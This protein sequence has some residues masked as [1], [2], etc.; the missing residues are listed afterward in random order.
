MDKRGFG[1]IPVLRD[2][3]LAGLA[4]RADGCYFDGTFGRGGHARAILERLG[5]AGRLL[6]M[7]RD[8][9]AI[10][11]AQSEFG[12]D[13]RVGIR[14]GNFS[15]VGAWDA[16]CAGLDGALLDLG[17]SSPQLDDAAR[18]FSFQ[19]DAPLDMR[20]DPTAG[21]SAADFLAHADASAI[22]DVLFRFGEERM[23]RRIAGAIVAQRAQA[24]ITTTRALAALVERVL[25]RRGRGKHPAT[26][27]FQALRI[28]VN[29]ELGS[30]QR[31][32]PALAAALR[33]G[34]RLAVI[35]FH[36]L[37]DRIVKQ[38]MRGPQPAAVRRGLPQPPVAPAPLRAIGR[39]QKAEAGEVAANP[40]ARSAVLRLAEKVAAEG[41]A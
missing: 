34:G 29:D 12:H 25:G 8:P 6:V 23:S 1:H 19:A 16:A 40:R 36:S 33:P 18:G 4:V 35:S 37:E 13:A 22:A 28:Y 14:R 10:A 32:L 7:D 27:T 31:A 9:A 41:H 20:M 38:F 21:V 24:P 30:L 39:A 3:V 26:R 2:A 15:D 5:P 11:V 17:V